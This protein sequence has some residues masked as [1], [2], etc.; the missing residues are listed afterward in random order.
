MKFVIK[1]TKE[2]LIDLEANSVGEAV[3]A[4]SNNVGDMDDYNSKWSFNVSERPDDY[5]CENIVVYDRDG[6]ILGFLH[7]NDLTDCGFNKDG[8]A[9]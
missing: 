8:T 6:K 3:K 1:Y 5:E 7:K 2:L 4:A 9:T